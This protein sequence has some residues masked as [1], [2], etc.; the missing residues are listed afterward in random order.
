[1]AKIS[2]GLMPLAFIDTAETKFEWNTKILS[3]SLYTSLVAEIGRELL[4]KKNC[5]TSNVAN[6]FPR[7]NMI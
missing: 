2:L 7:I 6:I 3:T 1:M 4:E 5:K